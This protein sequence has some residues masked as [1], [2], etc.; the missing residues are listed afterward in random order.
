MSRVDAVRRFNRFYTRRIGALQ[1]HF[2]GAPWPLP[3]ARVLYELGQRG[4]CTASALCGE[5]DLDAG[6]LSRLLQ[7]LRRQGLVQ[8]MRAE[9]DARQTRLSLTSKGRKAFTQLDT[10]SRDEVSG[11]LAG[12][13]DRGNRL[14]EALTTVESLLGG[15][16]KRVETTL[17]AHRPGDMGWVIERHGALYAQEYGWDERFEALVAGIAAKFIDELDPERERCWIAERGGE[18]VGCVFLV[19]QNAAVAKLRLLIVDPSARGTGLGR[20]LVE[21][22]IAFA[23]EKGYRKLVLWTQSN[24]AAARAIYRKTGFKLVKTEKHDSF[25]AKLTGEYWELALMPRRRRGT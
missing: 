4:E 21:A 25:G 2:L 22:C 6:Y 15:E 10:R 19:R 13:P 20:R 3:Q 1:P 5:L 11:M 14:V 8:G 24:L 12:L 9:H 16:R 23:R 18:R 7:G 17:R